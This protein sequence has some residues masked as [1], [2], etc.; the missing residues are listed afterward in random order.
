[1]NK[2]KYEFDYQK[3]FGRMKA[4]RFSQH[5]LAQAIGVS[6]GTMSVKLKDKP[7]TQDEIKS[8]CKVLEIP[9][10]EM[11]SY[12]FKVKVQKTEQKQFV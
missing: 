9:D 10:K 8:I 2:P 1:M 3:L 11:A 5:K 12:F 6:D 7:F 4:Y